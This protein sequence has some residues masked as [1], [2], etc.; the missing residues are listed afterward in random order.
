[1]TLSKTF[2]TKIL[3]AVTG[4]FCCGMLAFSLAKANPPGN[5]EAA[6]NAVSP[7][8]ESAAKDQFKMFYAYHDDPRGMVPLTF[9][10]A[11]GKA[12]SLEDYRGKVVVLNFWATWCAPCAKEL[13]TLQALQTLRGG[14]N[15]TVL[16]ASAD[17]SMPASRIDEFMKRNNA[18]TLPFALLDET[19]GVWEIVGAGLPITFIIDQNGRVIYKMLGEADWAQPALVVLIDNLLANNAS[20]GKN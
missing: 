8:I 15:F 16:A 18:A 6:E 10:D 12:G 13:P 3:L 19:D 14:K 5:P 4:V 20:T 2:G 1:M 7:E 9:R 17:F 11:A